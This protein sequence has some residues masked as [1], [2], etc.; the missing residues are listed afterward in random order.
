MKQRGHSQESLVHGT[1]LA[2]DT[3]GCGRANKNLHGMPDF[4]TSARSATIQVNNH[5]QPLAFLPMGN[6]HCRSFPSS[7]GEGKI[8]SCSG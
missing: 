1:L 3:L 5:N 4:L 8:S 7:D 2:R 6:R